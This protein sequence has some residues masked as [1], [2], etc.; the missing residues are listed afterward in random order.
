M[1]SLPSRCR[2]VLLLTSN[3]TLKKMAAKNRRERE[4]LCD[5]MWVGEQQSGNEDNYLCTQMLP[6]T[7]VS[8]CAVCERQK[9]SAGERAEREKNGRITLGMLV[10]MGSTSQPHWLDKLFPPQ[11][12]DFFQRWGTVNPGIR[13]VGQR[14]ARPQAPGQA[15]SSAYRKAWRHV[16]CGSC[17]GSLSGQCVCAVVMLALRGCYQWF[18]HNQ[19]MGN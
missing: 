5:C 4:I 11:K 3:F 16:S 17:F 10:W 13:S 19:A 1:S 14:S 15:F 9:P 18:T 8:G 6:F 12:V 7:R 2:I